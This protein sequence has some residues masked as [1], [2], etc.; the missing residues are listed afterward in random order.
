[1]AVCKREGKASTSIRREGDKPTHV[2]LSADE[3]EVRLDALNTSG[4]EGVAIQVVEDEEDKKHRKEGHVELQ[5][6][7][8]DIISTS[9]RNE[10]DRRDDAPCERAC[11]PPP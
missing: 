8:G 1:M 7:E 11:A 6:E 4:G 10:W 2:E 3:S 5:G 9:T